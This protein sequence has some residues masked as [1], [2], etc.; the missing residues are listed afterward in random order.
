MTKAFNLGIISGYQLSLCEEHT[1]NVSSIAQ[2]RYFKIQPKTIDIMSKHIYMCFDNL[3]WQ[4][5]QHNSVALLY[6]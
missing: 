6:I 3:L 1:V 2:F 5:S 4:I